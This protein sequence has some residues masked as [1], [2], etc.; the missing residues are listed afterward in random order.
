M[1]PKGTNGSIKR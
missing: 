1:R